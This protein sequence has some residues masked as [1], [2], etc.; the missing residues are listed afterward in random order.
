[1][2]IKNFSLTDFEDWLNSF[3]N[4]EKTPK[5]NIFWLDTMKFLASKFGNPQNSYPTIHVAGSK[6]KGSVSSFM[7]SILEEAGFRTGLYTSPHLVSFYER[8]A[9]AHGLFDPIIYEKA[10]KEMLENEDFFKTE[11]LPEQRSATWFELVTL[12]AFLAF[13]QATCNAVVLETGLGGRL[14]A[15][16][17]VIPKVSVIMPIEL[18][19]TEFLGD[20]I[21][22]IAYEKAGIIKEGVP[23]VCASQVPQARSV[24]EKVAAE[25]NSPI[26][27]FDDFASIKSCEIKELKSNVE[28]EFDEKFKNMFP[29]NLSFSTRLLG[30]IQAMNAAVA[31]FAVKLCFPQISLEVIEAGLSKAFLSARF[32]ICKKFGTTIIFDGAHTPNSMNLTM[33]T[34]SEIVRNEPGTKNGKGILLFGCAKDKNMNELSKIALENHFSKIFLTKPGEK[35]S[36]LNELAQFFNANNKKDAFTL[37][38]TQICAISDWDE[39]F[40]RAVKEAQETNQCL[41]IC[42]SF[43]LAAAIKAKYFRT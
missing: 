39:A 26:Y 40:T 17:I 33:D 18:E 32:E 8:V 28:I 11:N 20:T 2:D 34:F 14:D 12:F 31:S 35:L 5:K 3:L 29:R 19:H 43:Y 16:N 27:F 30:N 41:L 24:F 1:M 38:P 42:G 21:E 13:R 25:K 15:T 23:V 36:D 22:K 10:E 4:F 7:A 6:G 37:Q 9:S